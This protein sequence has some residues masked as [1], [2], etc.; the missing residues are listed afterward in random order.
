MHHVPVCSTFYFIPE[1]SDP[2]V[3][4]SSKEERLATARLSICVN[5][6]EDICGMQTLGQMEVDPSQMIQCVKD[7]ITIAKQT[8]GLVRQAW[9]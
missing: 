1:L 2:I 7:A 9:D 6:Y 3:D 8:T 5:I 4:A